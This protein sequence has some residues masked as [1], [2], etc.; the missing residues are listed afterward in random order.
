MVTW[1]R[2]KN[3]VALAQ[4]YHAE[5][6]CSKFGLI[7]LSGLG[8]DSETNG[9][10]DRQTDRRVYNIPIGKAQWRLDLILQETRMFRIFEAILT[11]I[12]SICSMRN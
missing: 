6:S 5:K 12:K 2:V 8:G 4:P 1:G 3:D 9:R 10:T 11:N 7:Q